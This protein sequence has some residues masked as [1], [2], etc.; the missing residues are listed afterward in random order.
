[1]CLRM[2]N[3][4]TVSLWTCTIRISRITY[5]LAARGILVN[6]SGFKSLAKR[7]MLQLTQ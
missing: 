7:D 5:V 1:M 3:E 6:V 4:N 2:T